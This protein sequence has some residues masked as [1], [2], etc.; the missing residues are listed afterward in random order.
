MTGGILSSVFYRILATIPVIGFVALFVFLLLRL[1]PGDPALLIGGDMATGEDLERIRASLGLDRP[2]WSQFLLWSER[3]MAGDLGRSVF[4]GEQVTTLI[5]QRLEP[6]IALALT[7]VVF[8]VMTAVP[9][10]VAAAWYAGSI[11]D[12]LLSV[13]AV[14]AFSVPV[15]LIGYFLIY[16]FSV[17]TELFPV[18]GYRALSEGIG[19]F[20]HHLV[21]PAV[22][23]GLVYVALLARMTRSTML[24][25]L[26]QDYIRTARA[27]GL[28]GARVLFVHALR[29]AGGPIITTIG[30]GLTLLLGGVVVTE[31][32]FAIPGLGRLVVDSMLQR[33]YPVI[34]GT[35]LFFS[36]LYLMINLAI[37]IGYVLLDPRIRK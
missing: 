20:L 4:S 36:V 12:R 2:I 29:N 28:S 15:F 25:V 10:G 37:D 3:V 33:D 16:E 6:T 5:A 31:S 1:T 9:L 13:F 26:D 19:P 32:V 8:S 17:K 14:L 30:V 24:E 22:S 7:V 18:H 35:I 34:Q 11:I 23:L 27:K 21:L